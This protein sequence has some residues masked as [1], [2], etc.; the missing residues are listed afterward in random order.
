VTHLVPLTAVHAQLGPV[1]ATLEDLGGGLRWEDVHRARPRA[2]LT[3]A[4]CSGPVYPKR[5]PRGLRF[6]AHETLTP[7]CP[8][9]GESPEHHL[10]KTELAGTARQA[11]WTCALE[12]AGNGWRADVLA[13]HPTGG[14]ALAWEAQLSGI[15]I[16]DIEERTRRMRAENVEV[17]WVTDRAPAWLAQAPSVRVERVDNVLAVVDGLARF[18]TRWCGDRTEIERE[19]RTTCP[20]HGGWRA[21][22]A[23][24]LVRFAA[25]VLAD[26]VHPHWLRT[27]V[28]WDWADQGRTLHWTTRAYTTSETNRSSRPGKPRPNA[29]PPKR[30]PAATA[31]SVTPHT[32][33]VSA[34]SDAV[35]TP[36]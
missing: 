27:A 25:A 21:V 28:P 12:V 26:S 35:R 11:G 10:L 1:D 15:T 7:N 4:G 13:R 36:S 22:D 20:G 32:W 18:E 31:L 30:R 14:R 33:R 23:L 2:P 29:P 19:S 6:F 8:H 34:G 9:H 3:C 5:S 24:P 16:E 17:C